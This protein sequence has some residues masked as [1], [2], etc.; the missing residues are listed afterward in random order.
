MFRMFGN[1][2]ELIRYKVV[3]IKNDESF[4]ENCVSDSDKDELV[5][6]LTSKGFHFTV[7]PVDQSLNEW[8]NGLEFDNY[9]DALSVF[10]KGEAS[11]NESIFLKTALDNAQLRA[12]LD[13][14]TLIL[15]G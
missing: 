15:G 7:T 5:S 10:E 3:Y 4:Y 14:I 9:D 1:K 6:F 12:D 13:Y 2:I 11:Y 8:F